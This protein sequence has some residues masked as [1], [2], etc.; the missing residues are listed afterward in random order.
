M[1]FHKAPKRV[2]LL[3]LQISHVQTFNFLGPRINDKLKWNTMNKSL[4]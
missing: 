1:L 2:P 3:H 4:A